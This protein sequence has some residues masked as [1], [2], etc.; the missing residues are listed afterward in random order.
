MKDTLFE[1]GDLVRINIYSKF[2]NWIN[3]ELCLVLKHWH[4][5]E[6]N[7]VYDVLQFRTGEIIKINIYYLEKVS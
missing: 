1:P 5:N 2:I 4:K 6:V 3:G 7:E